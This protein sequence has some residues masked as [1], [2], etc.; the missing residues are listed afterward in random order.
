MATMEEPKLSFWGMSGRCRIWPALRVPS[1]MRVVVMAMAPI[2]PRAYASR[3]VRLP[4]HVAT[5]T[6][7]A[8]LG[9]PSQLNPWRTPLNTT[10]RFWASLTPSSP[11]A[12]DRDWAG[13]PPSISASHSLASLMPSRPMTTRLTPTAIS[14]AEEAPW[15]ME[16]VTPPL[17]SFDKRFL[18]A[19]PRT[20]S[21]VADTPW[22][23]P[24]S[25]P[26]RPARY[27]LCP[28][29]RGSSAARWS[30]PAMA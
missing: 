30:G 9:A 11:A 29:V 26:I 28:Q 20:P 5:A 19:K 14:M 4:L 6:A 15:R 10:A 3:N 25:A 17:A 27:H 22:P 2:V 23:M 1:P 12:A 16:D 7:G 24:H 18:R 13:A 21:S 8:R